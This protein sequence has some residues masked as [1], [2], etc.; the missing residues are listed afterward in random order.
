[1]NTDRSDTDTGNLTTDT[2]AFSVGSSS[3]P[4]PGG[5]WLKQKIQCRQT[6]RDLPK[7]LKTV[8]VRVVWLSIDCMDD[9]RGSVEGTVLIQTR[10]KDAVLDK[11]MKNGRMKPESRQDAYFNPGLQIENLSSLQEEA[12]WRTMVHNNRG[13]AVVTEHRLVTGTFNQDIY[14]RDFP[15]DIQVLKLKLKSSLSIKEVDLIPDRNKQSTLVDDALSSRLQA[16]WQQYNAMEL[17]QT[18]KASAYL[19]AEHTFPRLDATCNIARKSSRHVW[20]IGIV[21][22]SIILMSLS[23]FSLP[24]TLEHVQARLQGTFL[25]VTCLIVYQ[26][27]YGQITGILHVVRPN[28]MDKYAMFVLIYL[29]L[30]GGWH[31]MSPYVCDDRLPDIYVLITLAL[32]VLMAHIAIF[33]WIHSVALRNR[34]MLVRKDSE[35]KLHTLNNNNLPPTPKSS[36]RQIYSHVAQRTG[37]KGST[38]EI[39]HLL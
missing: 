27:V 33:I 31:S 11:L 15:F 35:A 3:D 38:V 16:D 23:L 28:I 2:E 25:L 24:P 14:L 17:R 20:P 13:Q 21:M 7:I 22:M 36:R 18:T 30:N 5:L 37:V 34:K 1:M 10:W 32:L 39:E 19:D 26:I 4:S 29:V 9:V 12:V 8:H 6:D